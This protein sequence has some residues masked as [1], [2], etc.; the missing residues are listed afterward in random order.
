MS[1]S[2]QSNGRVCP[3]RRRGYSRGMARLNI[4]V[5]ERLRSRAVARAREGGFSTV[6]EYVQALLLADAVGGPAVDDAG[7][8]DLLLG[9]LDGPFVEADPADFRRIRNKFRRRVKAATS[10]AASTRS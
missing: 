10:R 7:I 5:P 2:M 9:R 3:E 8:R 6:D 1:A 4:Q